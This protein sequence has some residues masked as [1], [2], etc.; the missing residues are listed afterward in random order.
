MQMTLAV[1]A[2]TLCNAGMGLAHPRVNR[3]VNFSPSTIARL[4]SGECHGPASQGED[5]AHVPWQR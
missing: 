3:G 2:F 4:L 5:R 1:T